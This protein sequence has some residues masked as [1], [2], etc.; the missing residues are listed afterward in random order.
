MKTISFLNQ[1][2]GVGKSTST[3]NLAYAFACRGRKVLA[4]DADP[5][6]SLTQGI[7]GPG[8][9]LGLDPCATLAAIFR[10]D[11]P[12]PEDVIRPTGF[13][14][15]DVLPG[16]PAAASFNVPDPHRADPGVQ[17]CLRNFLAEVASTY[18][19]ALIDCPPN[20]HMAS[21][22]ALVASDA[23]IV[24]L[25]PEDYGA[26]GLNAVTWSYEQVRSGPNPAVRL[27]GFLL[28]RVKR[29]AIHGVYEQILRDQYGTLVFRARIAESADF[30]EAVGKRKPVGLHK[31]RSAAA[32]AVAAVAEELEARLEGRFESMGREEVAA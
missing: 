27:L 4:I 29:L 25:T 10:G 17:A 12:F 14:G 13:D 8:V 16:S 21:W 28:S 24:P 31:P 30:L 23:L 11:D 22:S 1:K 15:V 6:A 26:Q 7:F 19:L 9:A 20:L 18:D 32:K 2:G 3:C 5:Q